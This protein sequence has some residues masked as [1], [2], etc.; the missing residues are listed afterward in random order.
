MHNVGSWWRFSNEI[1]DDLQKVYQKNSQ[2]IVVAWS[3]RRGSDHMWPW[4]QSP[5]V[6]RLVWCEGF[7]ATVCCMS[8]ISEVRELHRHVQHVFLS[9]LAFQAGCGSRGCVHG[10]PG[11]AGALPIT[12]DSAQTRP[13]S[14]KSWKAKA[15][16]MSFGMFWKMECDGGRRLCKNS[17]FI[18]FWGMI[19]PV[20]SSSHQPT[21]QHR[22][23]TSLK[24]PTIPSCRF[25]TFWWGHGSTALLAEPGAPSLRIF[26]EEFSDFWMHD[27]KEKHQQPCWKRA[28]AATI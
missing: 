8:R 25:C 16:K 14:W 20:G 28:L 24:P 23:A 17:H 9:L 15:P 11:T 13:N 26:V 10:S 7:S 1:F 3:V 4:S 27:E 6:V 5:V 19:V 21:K 2:L 12:S 18:S 22:P